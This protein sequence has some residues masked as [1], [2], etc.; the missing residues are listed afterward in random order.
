MVL[1]NC[2]F[3]FNRVWSFFPSPIISGVAH[4]A[5][6]STMPLSLRTVHLSLGSVNLEKYNGQ[7]EGGHL[8]TDREGDSWSKRLFGAHEFEM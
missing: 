3:L 7:L 1:L 6:L 5:G 2:S 8:L 4:A